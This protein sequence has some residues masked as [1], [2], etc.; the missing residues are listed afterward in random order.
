MECD[1]RH[2]ASVTFEGEEGVWV[3]G[4]DVVELHSV[5]ASSSKEPLVGRDAESVYL[6]VGMLDGSRA[7]A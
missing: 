1:A 4:F 2:I 5:M 7:D 3:R 6:G